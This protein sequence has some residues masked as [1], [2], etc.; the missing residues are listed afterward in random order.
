MEYLKQA[1][2]TPTSTDDETTQIV[3]ELLTEIERDGEAA[4]RRYADEFPLN[5]ETIP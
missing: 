4:V 5:S 2:S 1:K 3:S